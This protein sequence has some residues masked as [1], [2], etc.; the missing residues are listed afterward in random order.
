MLKASHKF[1]FYQVTGY[2]YIILFTP[3]IQVIVAGNC[4]KIILFV[5]C[6]Y[7]KC[8][9]KIVFPIRYKGQTK[10]QAV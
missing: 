5:K 1:N 10:N 7:L 8:T 4:L 2:K 6:W 9:M 3:F